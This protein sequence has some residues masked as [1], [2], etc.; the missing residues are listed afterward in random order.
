MIRSIGEQPLLQLIAHKPFW[1]VF[2]PDAPSDSAEKP[3]LETRAVWLAEFLNLWSWDVYAF[4]FDEEMSR[5]NLGA[6]PEV[7]SRDE[8]LRLLLESLRHATDILLAFRRHDHPAQVPDRFMKSA[9]L[10][11]SRA[12]TS[13]VQLKDLT[14]A[15]IAR[16]LSAA[17]SHRTEGPREVRIDES[18]RVFTPS[19]ERLFQFDPERV[20]KGQQDAQLDRSRTLDEIQEAEAH[21]GR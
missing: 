13:Q 16:R 17:T 15:Q 21:D 5:E 9:N 12:E 2:S 18:G 19:G 10:L 14:L 8:P 20:L 1:D 11:L 3:A 6:I 7:E 4:L